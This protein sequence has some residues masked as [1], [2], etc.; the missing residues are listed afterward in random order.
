MHLC[1]VCSVLLVVVAGS[2]TSKHQDLLKRVRDGYDNGLRELHQELDLLKA[3]P[4]HH[5]HHHQQQQQQQ[6]S[7]VGRHS[8]LSEKRMDVLLRQLN[9]L[10]KA[11]VLTANSHI[12]RFSRQ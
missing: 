8:S 11:N 7:G 12:S 2:T 5:H 6:Q 4:P 10:K 9:S 1:R 3:N